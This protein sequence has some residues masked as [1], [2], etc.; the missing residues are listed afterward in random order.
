MLFHDLDE[1]LQR[2]LD[3]AVRNYFSVRPEDVH[4]ASS[5]LFCPCGYNKYKWNSMRYLQEPHKTKYFVY[6]MKCTNT[7]QLKDSPEAAIQ[8]W[9]AEVTLLNS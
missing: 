2:K 8:A 3:S 4:D 6:C 9:N 7:G 5:I 1:K